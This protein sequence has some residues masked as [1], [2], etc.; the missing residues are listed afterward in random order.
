[1]K[2]S[3]CKQNFAIVLSPDFQMVFKEVLLVRSVCEGVGE[4]KFRKQ[5]PNKVC[6][7]ICH[8]ND[9]EKFPRMR[10][11]TCQVKEKQSC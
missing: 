5:H 11:L 9:A 2:T 6:I 10:K 8:Q 7:S 4:S 1:M 3:E